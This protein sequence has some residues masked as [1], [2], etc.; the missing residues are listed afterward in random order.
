MLASIAPEIR[1]IRSD[2]T[3]GAWTAEELGS[4]ITGMI[5]L[6]HL[7]LVVEVGSNQWV[8]TETAYYDC[9]PSD[10]DRFHDYL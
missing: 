10:E 7:G 5:E 4:S 6:C 1:K 2:P 8:G 3:K 9:P